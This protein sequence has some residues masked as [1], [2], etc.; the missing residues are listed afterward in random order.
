MN[1]IDELFCFVKFGKKEHMENLLHNG[2]LYF[3]TP[4][5]YKNLQSIDKERGDSNEGA[6]CV[7]NEHIKSI[8]L[9]HSSFGTMIL[10]PISNQLSKIIQY[11]Y[12]FLSYSLLVISSRT[13]FNTNEFQIDKRILNMGETDT[14]VIIT[15]PYRFLSSVSDTL[16]KENLSYK[17]G[18]VEYKNID[19]RGKFELNPFIKKIDHQ[20]Q[21]EYRLIIY[22]EV[23]N[24]K[25]IQIKSI[26]DYSYLVSAKSMIETIW[27]VKRN[28]ISADSVKRNPY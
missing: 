4:S 21:M 6:E 22:N 9:E 19:Q 15:D 8:K 11:N 12:Y 7:I 2:E 13:F 3:N 20:Y 27:N 5:V 18:L 10:N 16:K 24:A 1:E 25:K 17:F 26:A 23:D 14:A 28:P